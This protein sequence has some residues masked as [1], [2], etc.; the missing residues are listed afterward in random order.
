MRASGLDHRSKS[1]TETMLHSLD[2]VMDRRQADVQTPKDGAQCPSR[3]QQWA[4]TEPGM[5]LSAVEISFNL[6]DF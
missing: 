4:G 1:S 6:V 3:L 2:L 5:T